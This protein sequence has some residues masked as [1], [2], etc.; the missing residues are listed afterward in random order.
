[1]VDSVLIESGDADDAEN[2][3]AMFGH[4]ALADYVHPDEQFTITPDLANDALDISAGKAYI[5]VTSLQTS[6]GDERRRLMVAVEKD[7]EADVAIANVDARNYLFLD[8][9]LGVGDSPQWVVND[10]GAAPSDESLL[11]ATVDAEDSDGDESAEILQRVE[12]YNRGPELVAEGLTHP[13]DEP[14]D[15]RGTAFQGAGHDEVD[16]PQTRDLTVADF[17]IGALPQGA[18]GNTG[19]ATVQNGVVLE[20]NYSLEISKS[21]TGDSFVGFEDD[22]D[23]LPQFGDSF[24]TYYYL[25]DTGDELNFALFVADTSVRWYNTTSVSIR[26]RADTDTIQIEEYV[27]GNQQTNNSSPANISN[28]LNEVLTV[29]TTVTSDR[30][31]EVTLSDSTG[32]VLATGTLPTGSRMPETGGVQYRIQNPNAAPTGYFDGPFVTRRES[33][34]RAETKGGTTQLGNEVTPTGAI[35]T[36]PLEAP[37]NHPNYPLANE[38]VTDD[39]SQGDPVRYSLR[40]SERDILTIAA[41][42]DG[43]GGIQNASVSLNGRTFTDPNATESGDGMTANPESDT[44]DGF[45]PVEISG[46][47][48]QIPI[49]QS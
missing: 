25:T 27:N 29:D 16:V 48:Y 11:V 23:T 49:Y 41:E 26:V 14:I 44:E 46:T 15:L 43:L 1:M 8:A 42:A 20:G 17:E 39:L 2:V 24:T 6:G 37:P 38:P 13:D 30:V 32:S 19:D 22:R 28:H 40:V 5:G 31:V 3:D 7:P 34:A 9:Q 33:E 36:G 10:T 47:T 21:S 35:H 12:Y 18:V 4:P 45:V